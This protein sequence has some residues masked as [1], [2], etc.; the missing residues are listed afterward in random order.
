MGK[1]KQTN[2]TH[3]ASR[4]LARHPQAYLYAGFS[5]FNFFHMIVDEVHFVGGFA[6]SE[7]VAGEKLFPSLQATRKLADHESEILEHMNSDHGETLDLYANVL[8]NKKGNAWKAS[9]VDCDGIDLIKGHRRARLSFSRRLAD[10]EGVRL[11][12]VRLAA[13]ARGIE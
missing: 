12:L 7:W 13:E 9:G 3:H 4:F 6:A 5:D 8:C 10:P 11:E 1:I 2:D